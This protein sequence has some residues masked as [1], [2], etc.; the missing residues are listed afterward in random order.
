MFAPI[1]FFIG[2]TDGQKNIDAIHIT[3]DKHM[4]LSDF[5]DL[6][7]FLNTNT[8]QFVSDI[9]AC[10]LGSVA[11]ERIKVKVKELERLLNANVVM[12]LNLEIYGVDVDNENLG[13]A[14]PFKNP[15]LVI[16]LY[17][18]NYT[19]IYSNE[20]SSVLYDC[21]IGASG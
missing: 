8:E 18:T 3:L 10:K 16:D 4:S 5:K 15:V 12:D 20:F 11:N 17:Q 9:N 21:L 13:I 19:R 1:E 6:M 2:I 7:S 14:V